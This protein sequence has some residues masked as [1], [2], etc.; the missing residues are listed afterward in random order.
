MSE[1]Q[2]YEFQAID[3]PVSGKDFDVLEQISSRAQVTPTS[4]IN[5]Y[6]YG[7]FRGDPIKLMEKY[8]DAFVYVS[9]WGH[10]RLMLKVPERLINRF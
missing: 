9:N 4:F 3:K 7:D 10:R 5:I 6:N 2:Y 1:Y 8:Y